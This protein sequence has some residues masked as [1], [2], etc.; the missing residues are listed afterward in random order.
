[1]RS[2]RAHIDHGRHTALAFWERIEDPRWRAAERRPGP[3]AP[4]LE[5]GLLGDCFIHGLLVQAITTNDCKAT[6]PQRAAA[7]PAGC[8]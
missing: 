8:R 4:E 7:K 2:L 6:A 3:P 5:F 1:M